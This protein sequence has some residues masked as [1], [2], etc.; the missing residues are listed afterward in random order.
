MYIVV[1]Y[2]K[3][4]RF[5]VLFFDQSSANDSEFCH[6]GFGI[7]KRFQN[8]NPILFLC[9][10]KCEILCCRENIMLSI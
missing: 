3:V 4:V 7:T 10:L 8:Q 2:N 9:H 1:I 5:G 6:F